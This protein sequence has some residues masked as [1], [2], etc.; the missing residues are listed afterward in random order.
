LLQQWQAERETFEKVL[1]SLNHQFTESDKEAMEFFWWKAEIPDA[2]SPPERRAPTKVYLEA[3]RVGRGNARISVHLVLWQMTRGFVLA[4]TEYPPDSVWEGEEQWYKQQIREDATLAKLVEWREADAPMA[5]GV[6]H[7][8][9]QRRGEAVS[10]VAR[11]RKA[12]TAAVR[13]D[14]CVAQLCASP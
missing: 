7:L 12:R 5:E 3:H 9:L 1:T 13:C 14:R 2:Q 6:G 10:R 4:S 11:P 8:A